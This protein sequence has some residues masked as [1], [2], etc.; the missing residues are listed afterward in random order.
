MARLLFPP[1][2]VLSLYLL[3]AG[4]S[5][6][7][8]G[9]A[10]GLVA[11]QAFVLRYFAGG[12]ADLR[13]ATPVPPWLLFGLGLMLAAT[14]GAVPLVFGEPLLTSAVLHA[15]VPVL[16]EVELAT[17][18]LFE[19]GVYLLVVGMVLELLRSLGVTIEY[20]AVQDG[21]AGT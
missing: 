19:I 18:L 21:R 5:G 11:G 7:G 14:V 1:V 16:G 10:G 4:H 13:A 6:T 2:L 3:F 12:R 9:F 17:S 15:E 20:E 8:S